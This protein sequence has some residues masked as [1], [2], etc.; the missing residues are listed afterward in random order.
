MCAKTDNFEQLSAFSVNKRRKVEKI[1]KELQ[2]LL[3]QALCQ[4]FA[5]ISKA[6]TK[7]NK[8]EIRIK[9]KM[10]TNFLQRNFNFFAVALVT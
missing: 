8:S 9:Y 10:S 2:S 6:E 7:K 5:I 1:A 3:P 4:L